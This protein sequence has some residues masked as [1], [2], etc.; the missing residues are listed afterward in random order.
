M[1]QPIFIR[2]END[3]E[4]AMY[5]RTSP[6]MAFF[7]FKGIHLLPNNIYPYRQRT[8]ATEGIELEN[9][10]E[11]LV[12]DMCD[13]E[14]YDISDFFSVDEVFQ[15]PDTGLPQIYWSITNV[16]DFDAGDQLIYLKIRQGAN[17]YFYS[18]PFVL[19]TDNSE[20]TSRWDY[21]NKP[22]EPMLSTQLKIW[23]K[24]PDTFEEISTYDT[25]GTG[26]RVSVSGKIIDYEIWQSGIVDIN[27]FGLFK[28]M[29]RNAYVYC[30]L[31]KTTPFEP[32]DTP[33]L[34]GKEN[35]AEAE[36][37]I[38]RD[39]N[40]LYDPLYVPPTPPTPEPPI[41]GI[42][43]S[44]VSSLNNSQVQYTFTYEN[45]TTEILTFQYSLDNVTWTSILLPSGSP[46]TVG[47]PNNQNE[48]YYYRIIHLPTETVSNTLQLPADTLE[49][50][51][52]TTQNVFN[53]NG[54]KYR[55]FYSYSGFTPIQNFIFQC[56]LDG[57]NWINMLQGNQVPELNIQYATTPASSEEFTYFRMLYNPQGI[58]SPTYEFTIGG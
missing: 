42:T 16:Q 19:T 21:R 15:D 57:V 23:F 27:L 55:F 36:I 41:L 10:E 26:S 34:V 14:L 30:D 22:T 40:N 3:L 58:I 24:Q 5:S 29:R 56:S 52:I 46:Q 44:S 8:Y 39:E 13:N 20:F 18:S 31:A 51:N 37:S 6:Q 2:I 17:A 43:L 49:I 54:N 9:P 53:P 11:V 45:F 35:F 47:V 4:K 25:L 1:K 48:G 28:Q 7:S 12:C 32:F 33:R 50:E 38:V